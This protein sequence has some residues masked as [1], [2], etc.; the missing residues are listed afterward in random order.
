MVARTGDA[1]FGREVEHAGL[2]LASLGS[3]VIVAATFE[4]LTRVDEVVGW[5]RFV[6]GLG[7]VGGI[8]VT[9][10]TLLVVLP[11][12]IGLPGDEYDRAIGFTGAA[13]SAPA[14]SRILVV[15]P[16]EALPGDSRSFRGASYRVVSAPIP[17][18]DEAWLSDPTGADRALETTL[19]DIIEGET[20]RA[21]EALADYGV[22]WVVVLGDTPLEAVFAA[23]LDLVALGTA[24][25]AA[26]TFDGATPARAVADDGTPWRRTENGYAGPE[27]PGRVRIAESAN[28]R[29]E[30]D[31]QQQDWANSLSAA[32]GAVTFEAIASRRTQALIAGAFVLVMIGLSIFGRWRA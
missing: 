29:W 11:G 15:G 25:G 6:V 24:E 14:S 32:D 4:A 10:A 2:V 30:P 31:W 17:T 27:S 5:R 3:A 21:G 7:T 23:Q 13:G 26:L 16:S 19:N 18:M 8:V 9:V 12:R 22:R 28:S 20:F 1:G